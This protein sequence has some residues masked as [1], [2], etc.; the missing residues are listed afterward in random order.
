MTIDER[1]EA[2]TQ[3][4]ELIASFHRDTEISIQKLSDKVEQLSDKLDGLTT[5][6]APIAQLVLDERRLNRLEGK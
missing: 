5:I 2:L 4:V 6:V 1:I 3:S